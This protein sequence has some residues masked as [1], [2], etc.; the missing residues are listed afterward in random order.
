M[1]RV[2]LTAFAVLTLALAA[3]GTTFGCVCPPLPAK[4]TPEEARAELVKDFNG[5]FAVFTGEV[6]ALD[7]FEVK[8]KLDKVWKGSLGDELVMRTGAIA[9]GDG[10]YSVSSCDYSFRRGEKYLVFTYGDTAAEMLAHACSRTK[11]ASRAEQEM[12]ALDE[13]APREKRNSKPEGRN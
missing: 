13:I 6:V 10:T 7:T 11:P 1:R 4:V 2:L 5:A 12:E 9:G 3:E 8:F